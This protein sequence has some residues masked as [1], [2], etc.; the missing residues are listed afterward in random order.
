M[1]HTLIRPHEPLAAHAPQHDADAHADASAAG[2]PLVSILIAVKNE[3]L[4][5]AQCLQSVLGQSHTR[6]E[7]IVVDDNSSDDTL[8]IAEAHRKLDARVKVLRSDGQGKVHAYNLAWS[9]SKGD[10]VGFFGGDDVMPPQ[11]LEHRLQVMR[12]HGSRVACGK[13]RS[14]STNP[15]YHHILYPRGDG[16]NYS[17]GTVLMKREFA[18]LVFPVPAQLPNEDLWA[19]LHI[20]CFAGAFPWSREIVSH[21]RIHDRNSMGFG[22]PFET[23]RRLLTQRALA[24]ALFIERYRSQLA[25]GPLRQMLAYRRLFELRASGRIVSILF[26]RRVGWRAKLSAI[27]LATPLAYRL[28]VFFERHLMGR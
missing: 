14:F 15:R 6:L 22:A 17:G 20:E 19:R 26:V 12:L 23:K 21:Y 28:R 5:L 11:S 2:A 25:P 27:S 4:Y 1:L 9:H 13:A 10:V 24:Y 3:G 8:A 18:E 16:P 7:V